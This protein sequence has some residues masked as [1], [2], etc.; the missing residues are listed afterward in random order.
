MEGIY[1]IW[2]K[3][4]MEKWEENEDI[5]NANSHKTI[6]FRITLECITREG[7]GLHAVVK[8]TNAGVDF[9]LKKFVLKT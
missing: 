7:F 2:K 6:T 8:T 9:H 4:Q 1:D 5:I 3:R